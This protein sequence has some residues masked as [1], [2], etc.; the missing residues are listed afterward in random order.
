MKWDLWSPTRWT[1]WLPTFIWFLH[2]KG[3]WGLVP[4]LAGCSGGGLFC[5]LPAGPEPDLS[6]CLSAVRG[7]WPRVRQVE[8]RT[9]PIRYLNFLAHC[10]S[11]P[12]PKGNG[13]KQADIMTYAEATS[14]HLREQLLS[15][16]LSPSPNKP[17]QKWNLWGPVS[18]LLWNSQKEQNFRLG[19]SF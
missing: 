8:Q 14:S 18:S 12:E 15:P 7:S 6:I 17:Q 4:T 2:F 19:F 11:K 16:W 3:V 5:H 9:L 10:Y 13:R 1:C